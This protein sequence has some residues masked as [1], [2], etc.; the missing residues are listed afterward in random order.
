MAMKRLTGDHTIP[1]SALEVLCAYDSDIHF[2]NTT[3]HSSKE[4]PKLDIKE[5]CLPSKFSDKSA[6]YENFC[7][8]EEKT[9]EMKI[10]GN[11]E[12]CL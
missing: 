7:L 12:T 10:W 11:E 6:K 8:D 3:V 9:A 2:V 4:N 5:S 1:V